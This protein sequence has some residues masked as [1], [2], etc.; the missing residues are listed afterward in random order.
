LIALSGRV[1]LT[2]LKTQVAGGKGR[3]KFS[4]VIVGEIHQSC[5]HLILPILKITSKLSVDLPVVV[6]GPEVN[7]EGI[8]SILDFYQRDF[9]QLYYFLFARYALVGYA[10]GLLQHT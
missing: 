4:G 3:N 2:L 6:T 5:T 1:L 9:P 7:D 8:G 10:L